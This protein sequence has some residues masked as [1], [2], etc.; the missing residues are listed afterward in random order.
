MKRLFFSLVTFFL[1]AGCGGPD[2]PEM[3]EFMNALGSP[4]Q[5]AAIVEK[6]AANPEIVPE[7]LSTCNLG[8]PNITNTE[9]HGDE[10]VFT[11]EAVVEKCDQSETAVGTI[12]VFNM[13]WKSGKIVSFEWQGPKSGNVEY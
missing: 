8:R 7:A 10:V 5:V 4:D 3:K 11:V 1:L 6:Y 2:V 9:T 13:G 12:R